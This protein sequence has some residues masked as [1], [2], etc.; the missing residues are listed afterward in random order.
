ML[1]L[2]DY[3]GHPKWEPL[4]PLVKFIKADFRD[5]DSDARRAIAERFRNSDLHLLAEKV[6]TQAELQEARSF[7]D[8][9]FQGLFV[10]QARY[11]LRSRH[12]CQ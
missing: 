7:G 9:F 4:I 8:S 5:A 11:G 2:D 3:I 10:L 6:E 12:S 1:A